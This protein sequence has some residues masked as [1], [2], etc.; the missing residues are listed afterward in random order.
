MLWMVF[1]SFNTTSAVKDTSTNNDLIFSIRQ[2]GP[3]S[4]RI[5]NKMLKNKSM[6]HQ[7]KA[8]HKYSISDALWNF[9]EVFSLK[10][11]L[12]VEG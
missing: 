7:L 5:I 9:V 3:I 2:I 6:I 1:Q 12:S 11:F 10:Y 4:H 8:I